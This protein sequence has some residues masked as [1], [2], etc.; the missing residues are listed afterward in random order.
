MANIH[1][2][3]TGKIDWRESQG[4]R[5][6]AGSSVPGILWAAC[7]RFVW[8]GELSSTLDVQAVFS[9]SDYLLY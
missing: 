6:Q 4:V 1:S 8:E 5:L 3:G 7:R 9:Y 2:K